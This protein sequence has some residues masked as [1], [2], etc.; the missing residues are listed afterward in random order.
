MIKDQML[1]LLQMKLQR[2]KNNP[3]HVKNPLRE[4]KKRKP[5]I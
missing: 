1:Q 3:L 5:K 2:N 4:I